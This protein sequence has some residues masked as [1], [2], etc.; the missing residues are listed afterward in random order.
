MHRAEEPENS[1][2][3]LSFH[4]KSPALVLTSKKCVN[5]IR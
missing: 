3:L 4:G 2:T 1:P 5:L